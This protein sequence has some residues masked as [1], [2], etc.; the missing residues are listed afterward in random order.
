M[1]T[2]I[3][4]AD[5]PAEDSGLPKSPTDV[6]TE[7]LQRLPLAQAALSLFR[8]ALDPSALGALFEKHRGRS[9]E[10]VVTFP[11]LVG[12]LFD[13]LTD[14][15]SG[16]QAHR[17]RDRAV[18]PGCNEAFYAK[19]RRLPV[20]LSV[21]FLQ[22]ITARMADLFPCVVNN[23]VPCSLRGFEILLLDGKALKQ[24]AKRLA[25]T[26][27]TPGRM[28]GGKL[29]VAYRL[30]DSQVIDMAV[31]LDGEGNE[32]ALV[33]ELAGRL[34]NRLG[35]RTLFVADRQ[36][37][38][39]KAFDEFASKTSHFVVRHAKSLGFSADPERPAQTQMDADGRT[40]T[41]E[42]GWVGTPTSRNRRQ[43]RRVSVTRSND[44]PLVVLSDLLDNEA[45]PAIDLLAVYRKRW[46]IESCFR[47]VTEVFE[48]GRF[49]GS[50]AEATVFQASLAFVLSNLQAV[51]SGYIAVDR[52]IATADLSLRQIRKDWHR[53][54]IALK[55][56]TTP[57]DLTSAIRPATTTE[58]LQIKLNEL[59]RG[60]W[61]PDWTKT[62]NAK[63][64]QHQ[65]K[66]KQSGAHTS[67]VRRQQL[68]KPKPTD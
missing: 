8:Y 51:L 63:P 19:L 23:A 4:P 20:S 29:L 66:A 18:T 52:G 22:D 40:V 33:P 64:R 58:E 48:L 46:D 59:L 39:L 68:A 6:A 61:R 30:R 25:C 54:L 3:L 10:S 9:Y 12:W 55:E 16:R 27:G 38:S 65:P 1:A 32:A 56:L 31:N 62:R 28:L 44:E 17:Q 7:L 21:G 47:D 60:L 67:V 26:R 37:S 49:I 45:V 5:R 57:A 15:G 36:F 35:I 14:V 34:R 50:T 41:E 13:A 42:W 11:H 2:M 43:V 53:Q 24:A